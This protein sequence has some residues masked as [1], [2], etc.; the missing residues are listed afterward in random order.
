MKADSLNTVFHSEILESIFPNDITDQFFDAL[1]GDKHE[2]AYD[3]RLAFSGSMKDADYHK[4][5][6]QFDLLQRP[7]KCL[8]CNLT[9]GLPTVFS[10]HP[11]INIQGV[12]Q[13]ILTIIDKNA[14]CVQ[15]E[16][17]LI[18]EINHQHHALPL[19]IIYVIE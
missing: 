17:G 18:Q 14:K 19:T 3:I 7:Q 1:Y 16:L 6:F 15:W 11:I 4:I 12:I 9:H 2:G 5:Y 8:A 13:K 10:R